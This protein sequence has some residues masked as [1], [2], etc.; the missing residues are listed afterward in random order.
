M[1]CNGDEIANGKLPSLAVCADRC[2]GVSSIFIYGTNMFHENRCSGDRCHCIC[3]L[4]S[5]N[6]QCKWKQVKHNGYIMYTY[7][8]PGKMKNSHNHDK[9][10]LHRIM[11]YDFH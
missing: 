5:S 6:Q 4:G 10:K 7:T 11:P 1:E 2:R 9:S 8:T 3:D